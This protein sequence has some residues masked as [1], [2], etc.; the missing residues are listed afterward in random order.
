MRSVS[1]SIAALSRGPA[2]F[3]V[4]WPVI[5]YLIF[6]RCLY[7]IS[8]SMTSS[9]AFFGP[10]RRLPPRDKLF[11]NRFFICFLLD[12][13]FSLDRRRLGIHELLAFGSILGHFRFFFTFD[14]I[15]ILPGLM[16][17]FAFLPSFLVTLAVSGPI[18][19]FFLWPFTIGSIL[20]AIF[21]LFLLSFGFFFCSFRTLGLTLLFSGLAILFS[22]FA[23]H[24]STRP[25]FLA[26][27]SFT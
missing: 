3:S 26:L 12:I 27:F 2:F 1:R 14:S 18:S 15:I 17:L 10:W 25:I 11:W 23:I 6:W 7:R 9:I 4:D 20:I 16:L 13:E 22:D 24:F 5:V 21:P 19:V 8:N